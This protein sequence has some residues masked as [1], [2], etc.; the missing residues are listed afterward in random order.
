MLTHPDGSPLVF[1]EGGKAQ[2]QEKKAPEETIFSEVSEDI[3]EG[4]SYDNIKTYNKAKRY[5]CTKC[6]HMY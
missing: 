2:P 4:I 6:N 5:Q 3:P 1:K